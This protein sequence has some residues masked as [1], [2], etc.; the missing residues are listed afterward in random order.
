MPYSVL[1]SFHFFAL[2]S[3][4]LSPFIGSY[5]DL[6]GFYLL[7]FDLFAHPPFCL[8]EQIRKSGIPRM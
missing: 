7:G 2:L 5:A 4:L 8:Y 3:V 1:P 6:F